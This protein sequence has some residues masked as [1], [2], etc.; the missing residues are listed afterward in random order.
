METNFSN[1]TT[2]EKNEARKGHKDCERVDILIRQPEKNLQM[3]WRAQRP[4]GDEG[5]SH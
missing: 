5:I 4:K 2:W 3:R 1:H